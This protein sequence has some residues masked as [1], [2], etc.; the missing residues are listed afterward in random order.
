MS[1]GERLAVLGRARRIIRS[2]NLPAKLRSE[3]IL[4]RTEERFARISTIQQVDYKALLQK[5]NA[6]A[7]S[8]S[9]SLLTVREMQLA[10]SCLFDGD[11]PVADDGPLLDQFLDALRSL[12]SR[13]AFRRLIHCYCNHFDPNN[14][15]IIKIGAFLTQSISDAQLRSE[16]RQRH[17]D[18]RL[19]DPSQ[20]PE[21]LA[22]LTVDTMEPWTALAKAGLRGPLIATALAVLSEPRP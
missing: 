17:R 1:L 16:W 10:A 13:T 9:F 14:P 8:R 12:K 22:R 6:V 3:E 18:Y 15:A 21:H 5:L 2:V 7:A 19:F 20:A 4:E 11:S